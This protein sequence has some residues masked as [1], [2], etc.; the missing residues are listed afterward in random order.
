MNQAKTLCRLCLKDKNLIKAHIIPE[1]FFRL[2]RSGNRSPEMHSNSPGSFPK[3][4]QVGTYDSNILCS[5]VT[6]P[7]RETLPNTREVA[8]EHD[9]HGDH[10]RAI[11]AEHRDNLRETENV[12]L[13]SRLV[14]GGARLVPT[15][16]CLEFP[17][18]DPQIGCPAYEL[19]IYNYMRI[20]VNGTCRKGGAHEVE[21]AD[22]SVLRSSAVP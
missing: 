18:T 1:G 13:L 19:S 7:I 2:L 6:A 20:E 10:M 4:M 17:G 14:G 12:S 22:A 11:L 5:A 16:L 21:K 8:S 3:R 9:R 15:C